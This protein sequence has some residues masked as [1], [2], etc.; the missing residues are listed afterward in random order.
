MT[1]GSNAIPY[2]VNWEWHNGFYPA[3]SMPVTLWEGNGGPLIQSVWKLQL[4]GW[5]MM[6]R[7]VIRKWCHYRHCQDDPVTPKVSPNGR[8]GVKMSHLDHQSLS[9]QNQILSCL[10][11]CSDMRINYKSNCNNINPPQRFWET[12]ER[13]YEG[14]PRPKCLLKTS[15]KFALRSPFSQRSKNS[16]VFWKLH[17]VITFLVHLHPQ[18]VPTNP[19]WNIFL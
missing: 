11:D 5:L 8:E 1:E 3:L 18:P 14:A 6:Q 12:G 15:H 4:I 2:T 9:R 17:D 19:H 13:D 7:S 16:A 10:S